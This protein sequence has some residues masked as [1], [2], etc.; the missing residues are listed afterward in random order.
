MREKAFQRRLVNNLRQYGHIQS[1]EDMCSPDIPDVSYGINSV[2]GWIE[3]KKRSKWPARESTVVSMDHEV[4]P[5]Q[6]NWL[7]ARGKAAG[8]CFIMVQVQTYYF[9]FHW[10]R[11]KYIG[12]LKKK[13]MFPYCQAWWK[14]SIDYDELVKELT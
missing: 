6:L 13:D 4:T 14:G 11:A 10:Q 9:L 1:H 5:G 2:N 7:E 12:H 8:Q 3:L